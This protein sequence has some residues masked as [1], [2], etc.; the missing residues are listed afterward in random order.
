MLD[1]LAKRF[2]AKARERFWG[3]RLK[4]RNNP[5]KFKMRN[6]PLCAGRMKNG[7]PCPNPARRG[8]QLCFVHDFPNHYAND[9]QNHGKKCKA[10]NA[11]TGEPCKNHAM[12]SLGLDV[13]WCHGGKS[14]GVQAELA[15]KPFDP[16]AG[17]ARRAKQRAH[18]ARAAAGV[19]KPLIKES[20][21]AF[22]KRVTREQRIEQRHRNDSMWDDF[23]QSRRLPQRLRPLYP[24]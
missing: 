12:T 2:G 10:H 1:A 14:V 3:D 21:A 6:V 18:R 15:A 8:S 9:I 24:C 13:C 16:V 4:G 11:R 7:S 5:G 23:D 17:A 20:W 19:I 22:E